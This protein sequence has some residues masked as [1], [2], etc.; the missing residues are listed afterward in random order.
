ML[1]S[2]A[3][4]WRHLTWR[5]RL[6]W[7]CVAV[8]TVLSLAAAVN[9][10]EDSDGL[11][12]VDPARPG[13]TYVIV[14]LLIVIDAVVPIFPGETT[15]NAAST[16]AAEGTLALVPVMVIGALGAI[17]VAGARRHS[18]VAAPPRSS[19]GEDPAIKV[20]SG[21]RFVDATSRWIGSGGRVIDP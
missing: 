7:S 12:I 18:R 14:F 3:Q 10:M 8:G 15:L 5:R 19:S 16:A 4:A 21:E 1:S 20:E 6:A 13:A 2:A 9:Y 11:T 17:V